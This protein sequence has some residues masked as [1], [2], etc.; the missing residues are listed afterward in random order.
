M[1]I[2]NKKNAMSKILSDYGLAIKNG[3]YKYNA[4]N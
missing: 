3:D 2:D 1:D 4:G